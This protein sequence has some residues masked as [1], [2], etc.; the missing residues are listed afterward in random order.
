VSYGAHEELVAS[1]RNGRHGLLWTVAGSVLIALFTYAL[2]LLLVE[3]L[4]DYFAARGDRGF[5][6]HLFNGTT[7]PTLLTVLFSFGAWMVAIWVTLR[8]VH[9]RDFRPMLGARVVRDFRRVL[10]ALV[11]LNIAIAILP[12]WDIL[13][14]TEPGLDPS[15]WLLLLPLSLLAVLIQVSAEEILFRGYLQQQLAASVRSPVVWMGLPSL[16]FAVAHYDASMGSNAWLIVIWAAVFAMLM[17]DITARSG[18]LGPAIAIHFVNN[19]IGILL[20][21]PPDYLS[22]LALYT[23]TFAMTDEAV[24][25]SLLPIDFALMIV[26]WLTAR[27]VLRC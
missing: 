8:W 22:G 4:R 7:P 11:G 27:L 24:V 5:A 15:R 1:A 6:E 20:V 2:T 10:V 21:S 12:P 9:G 25:R 19:A 17:A 18:S 14:E 3:T 13:A 26:S 16:L 23:Y